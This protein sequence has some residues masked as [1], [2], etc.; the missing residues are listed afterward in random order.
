MDEFQLIQRYFVRDGAAEDIVTGIGDDGAVLRPRPG[1][2]LVAVIDT[3]VE[4]VHFPQAFDPADLGFRAVAVNLSDIAAMGAE[5]RWMTLALTLRAAD[6][7]WLAGFAGGMRAAADPHDVILVGGDTTG[8]ERVVATV[9]ITGFIEAGAAIVRSGARIGD[10]IYVSGTIGDAA[11]GLVLLNG[12]AGHAD[13]VS[14]SGRPKAT[15]AGLH[16]PPDLERAGDTT[17]GKYLVSRFTRPTARVALGRALA[18]TASA[19]IDI[20]DGLYGDLAKLLEASGVGAEV[21]IGRLPL[22]PALTDC[23][24]V[25]QAREFALSGGDDYELCF[26]AP[27]MPDTEIAGVPVTAIGRVTAKPGIVLTENGKLVSYEDRG[28]VHFR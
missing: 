9:H 16:P 4:T 28:Y 18:G 21:D 10:R 3:L 27:E 20:S 7:A 22:S 8:G 12:T 5:P 6:D 14:R 25:E 15:P 23:F 26:T 1:K 19:A 24:G 2:D 13:P 11:A 17:T